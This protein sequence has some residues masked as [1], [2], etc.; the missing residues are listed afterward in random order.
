MINPLCLCSKHLLGEHVEHHMFIGTFKKKLKID[1]YIKNNLI[2]PLSLIKRH[3]ILAW[4]LIRRK[5][6]KYNK[7]TEHLTWI[8]ENEFYNLIDYLPQ[9]QLNYK[10]NQENAINDLLS[11]CLLCR[12]RYFK[13]TEYSLNVL[14]AYFLPSEVNLYPGL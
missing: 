6:I 12:E 4:E 9:E 8:N 10:I 13:L 14:N 5:F 11:R 3:N 2:E 7:F 1:G